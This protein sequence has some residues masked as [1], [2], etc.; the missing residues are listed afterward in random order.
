MDKLPRSSPGNVPFKAQESPIPAL[1]RVYATDMTQSSKIQA[2][3]IS[4]SQGSEA[5]VVPQE[6]RH[7]TARRDE[8]S[9]FID[10][11][12]EMIAT[13]LRGLANR[14]DDGETRVGDSLDLGILN[15]ITRVWKEELNATR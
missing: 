11:D 1:P 14:L 12:R 2:P 6:A 15:L 13:Y 5:S 7:M 4:D 8:T 3:R 9:T 10:E